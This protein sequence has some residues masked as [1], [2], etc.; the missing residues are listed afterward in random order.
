MS[1]NVAIDGPAGAGKARL[2][3]L[4][5]K[6]GLYLCGHRSNV[7]RHGTVHVKRGVEPAD[8]AAIADK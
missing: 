5:Q 6:E 8:A 3:E 2:Q 7:S 1:F 4:W